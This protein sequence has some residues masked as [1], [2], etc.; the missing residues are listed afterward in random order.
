MY[1][2]PGEVQTGFGFRHKKCY[3][4]SRY[5]PTMRTLPNTTD[6]YGELSVTP[7]GHGSLYLDYKSERIA[8]DPYSEAADFSTLPEATVILITHD[9]YDHYDPEAIRPIA[10]PETTFIAP[11]QVAE[12]LRK[13]GFEQPIITMANGDIADYK[14]R[15]RIEAV[16]AYNIVRER[17]PGQ[18]F[19]PKG[20]GNG[21]ILTID[22]KR[23]YIAGDTEVIP[24]M[25][26]INFI[27]IAF[28]P[29]MLPY[30]INEEEFI[31]AAKIIE[32]EFLYPYHYTSVNKQELQQALP[33]ITI[34]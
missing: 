26:E 14:D 19:H 20:E 21:Y 6:R 15:M 10:T 33:N 2:F 22:G 28:L 4:Y 7:I 30:T 31:Q 11:P 27:F 1:V 5:I 3:I 17:A 8:V 23:I 18:P 32:P 34:R 25:R 12:L 13:D 24:E 29:M 9:H 16:P